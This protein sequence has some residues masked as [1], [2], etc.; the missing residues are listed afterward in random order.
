[1]FRWSRCCLPN[2]THQIFKQQTQHLNWILYRLG[3]YIYTL[4]VFHDFLGNSQSLVP[5]YRGR[6]P[7]N[8]LPSV[9]SL[10]KKFQGFS[11]YLKTTVWFSP[12]KPWIQCIMFIA[13]LSIFLTFTWSWHTVVPRWF[14][15]RY[16]A[17]LAYRHEIVKNEFPRMLI[18][19]L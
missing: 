1:M 18:P 13:F 7:G 8:L 6:S 14:A 2:D 3:N 11:L 5:Q 15:P 12:S 19:P 4:T 9:F 10:R 16:I 17:T